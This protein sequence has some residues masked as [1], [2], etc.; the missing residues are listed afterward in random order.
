MI[1]LVLTDLDNTLIP[2]RPGEAFH[3]AVLSDEGVAAIRAL[4]DEGVHFGPATGRAPSS[5]AETFRDNSWAYATGAYS[6][7]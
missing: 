4:L 3:E 5:M 7:G 6:N 1:K 2:H